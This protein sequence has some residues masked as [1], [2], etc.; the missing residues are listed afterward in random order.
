MDVPYRIVNRDN[1]ST[2]LRRRIHGNDFKS[3]SLNFVQLKINLS[4]I[5]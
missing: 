1:L 2:K 4:R 5:S 3:E